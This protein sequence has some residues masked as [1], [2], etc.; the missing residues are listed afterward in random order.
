[1]NLRELPATLEEKGQCSRCGTTY[2]R[3]Y[4]QG[5]ARIT[6]G[7][8]PRCEPRSTL[9]PPPHVNAADNLDVRPVVLKDEGVAAGAE[10]RSGMAGLGVRRKVDE[11]R[12]PACGA[13]ERPVLAVGGQVRNPPGGEKY[14]V[15]VK[16]T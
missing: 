11:H 13:S 10:G 2:V 12:I 9:V 1:M 7:P 14:G 5:N 16:S 6:G 3:F 15:R 8:C 4:R